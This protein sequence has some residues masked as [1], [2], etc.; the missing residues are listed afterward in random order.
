MGSVSD[1][2]DDFVP[3]R[4]ED[5]ETAADE[6]ELLAESVQDEDPAVERNV[7]AGLLEAAESIR[8]SLA[9]DHDGKLSH[10]DR[11][12]CVREEVFLEEDPT[13]EYLDEAGWN[14]VYNCPL[15]GRRY[16]YFYG[17][18]GIYDTETKR[19]ITSESFDPSWEWDEEDGY[20]DGQCFS[21]PATDDARYERVYIMD[22]LYDPLD[23]E[24][25]WSV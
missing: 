21:I 20:H 17:F 6:L 8:V 2:T 25:I 9:G 24:Q 22:G 16:E 23:H 14:V 12:T 18:E 4:R 19:Y 3:V 15:C 5:A 1:V 13:D 7:R 10:P 11:E